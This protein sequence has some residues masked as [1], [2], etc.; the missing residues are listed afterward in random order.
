MTTPVVTAIRA[1]TVTG[2][3]ADYHD[4]AEGH[5]I[6]GPIATP[7]SRYP[8]YR[9]HRR[10]FGLNV[11]G[12]V[13]I[14]VDASDGSTGLGLTTGGV[15]AAWIVENHLARFVEGAPVDQIE[16]IWD[17]MFRSTL[18]YGRRGLALNAISGVDLALY[19]LLGQIRQLPVHALIGG[20]VRD[21]IT[22][23]ATGPR[24]DLA[25][26]MGF[27]G[28][29]VPLLVDNEGRPDVESATRWRDQ[30]SDDMW[31]MLD[32]WMSLELESALEVSNQLATADFRWL[33]EPLLPDDYWAYA[34]LRKRMP[35]TV[36]LSTG[37]HEATRWG[38]RMLLEMG[39]AD[40]I[41]P[42]IGWCGG[43]TELRRI[44]ALADQHGA[45]VVPHG[46]SVYSYH[47]VCTQAVSPFAEFL[48]MHPAGAEVVPMFSPLLLN[49]PVPQ[50]GRLRISDQPGFGVQLNPNIA[51]TRPFPRDD[52]SSS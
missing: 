8:E 40:I 25:E 11:L 15:P 14:E 32:C 31:L 38:F 16:R 13:A 43:L 34:E 17:Q 45:L 47:F 41:Q 39:C 4:Q 19:D 2:G 28:A 22:F 27:L 48:M 1:W 37:E 51:L 46:S 50:R 24:P 21:D 42:D 10:S 18:F 52:R 20:A 36:Q 5:W 44:A 6:D 3:G 29:K 12:T 26:Q 23:Y 30:V 9:A 7:M 33:E 49:E 35:A